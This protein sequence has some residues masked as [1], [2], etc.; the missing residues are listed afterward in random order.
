MLT[1]SL[2]YSILLRVLLHMYCTRTS[3]TFQLC[4]FF[5]VLSSTKVFE[6][7]GCSILESMSEGDYL[8]FLRIGSGSYGG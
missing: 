2:C 6:L 7:S 1:R 8:I 3:K 4:F 5:L